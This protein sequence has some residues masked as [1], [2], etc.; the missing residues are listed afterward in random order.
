[1]SPSV[2]SALE[3]LYEANEHE[4]F[5]FGVYVSTHRESLFRPTEA[6][7]LREMGLADYHEEGDCYGNPTW[8]ITDEGRRAYRQLMRI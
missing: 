2:Q 4:I 8:I 3:F 1:M 5:A 6:N 7:A